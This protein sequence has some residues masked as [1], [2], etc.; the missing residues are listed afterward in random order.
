[1]SIELVMFKRTASGRTTDEQISIQ[2]LKGDA[3]SHFWDKHKNGK[4]KPRHKDTKNS[5]N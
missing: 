3:I 1:M 4:R 2:A 5:T